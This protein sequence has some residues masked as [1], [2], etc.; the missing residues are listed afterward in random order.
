MNPVGELDDEKRTVLFKHALNE[1]MG[2]RARAIAAGISFKRNKEARH[3]AR[4]VRELA[5]WELGQLL[6]AMEEAGLRD[7]A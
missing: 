5:E 7:K 2:I 4:Q 3:K 6:H 1:V